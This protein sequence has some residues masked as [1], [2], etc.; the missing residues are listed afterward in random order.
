LLDHEHE[1]RIIRTVPKSRWCARSKLS[2]TKRRF[3]GVIS[4]IG[5]PTANMYRMP[6]KDPENRGSMP[7]AI[8]FY[9][10]ICPNL[11]TSHDALIRALSQSARG[12][13]CQEIMVASGVRYDLA[14]ES[15]PM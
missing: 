6:A 8:L 9:P 10:G 11:D 14:V 2:G 7:P 15:P 5:G 3:T 1:G 12:A 4:D 13:G